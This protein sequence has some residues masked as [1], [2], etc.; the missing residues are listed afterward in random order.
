VVIAGAITSLVSAAQR[1]SGQSRVIAIASDLAQSELEQLRAKKFSQLVALSETATVPAGG[2]SFTVN[3]TSGWAS[4]AATTPTGCSSTAN[5]PEALQVKVSVTWQ[6]MTRRPVE[7][8]TLIAAPVSEETKGNF[9]VQINDRNGAGVPAIPVSMTG[10]EAASGS[11]DADG[12]L[13]FSSL[14]QGAYTLAFQKAGYVDRD[15]VNA[16]SVRV[17]VNGGETG[18]KSFDYDQGGGFNVRFVR[19]TTAA[20]TPTTP[21]S[22][23]GAMVTNAGVPSVAATMSANASP[24]VANAIARHPKLLWPHTSQYGVHADNCDTQTAVGSV[25]VAPAQTA[26]AQVD[27]P[28][29][30]LQVQSDLGAYSSVA[31]SVRARFVTP[32]GTT[33]SDITGGLVGATT[34]WRSNPVPMPPGALPIVCMYGQASGRWYWTRSTTQSSSMADLGGRSITL[35]ANWAALPNSTNFSQV[36]SS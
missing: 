23:P 5:T 29:P 10:P 28:V 7:L 18:S 31:P 35:T 3:R 32:C 25:P 22:V 21:V 16:I 8:D 11:T 33:I 12:C 15:H 2:L 9:V 6:S 17:T 4:E 13:R 36:C 19:Q 14:E 1:E 27:I 24:S 30:W 26:P 34:V 20:P